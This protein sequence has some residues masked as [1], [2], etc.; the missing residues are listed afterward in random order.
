[1]IVS[2]NIDDFLSSL[3]PQYH[4]YTLFKLQYA[5]SIG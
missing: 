4:G 1:M 3:L 2:L 5:D